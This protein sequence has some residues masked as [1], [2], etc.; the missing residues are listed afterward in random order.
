MKQEPGRLR[1]YCEFD[2]FAIC[3]ELKPNCWELKLATELN[4]TDYPGI[5]PLFMRHVMRLDLF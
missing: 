3:T 5:S 1:R 4:L 2:L